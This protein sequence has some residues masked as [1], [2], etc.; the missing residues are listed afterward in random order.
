LLNWLRANASRYDAVIVHGLWQY[1]GLATWR[2]LVGTGTPYYVFPHGMLDPWFKQQFPLKHLKKT[3]YWPWAEYRVLRDAEAVLFTCEEE[4]QLARQT[5]SR[6]RVKEAVVGCGIS[7]PDGD[8]ERQR[9]KF[10]SRHPQLRD[11]RLML[12]LG[13][14]HPKKGCGQLIDAFAQ[15]AQRDPSLHLV[16]VGPAEADYQA[17]L[18][19][20]AEKLQLASRIC[21]TGMLRD[22]LKWGAYRA[23]EVFVLPSHQENF[24]ISVVEAL[25]CNVPV[26]VSNKVNIWRE[27]AEDRAGIVADD[28]PGGTLELLQSWLGLRAPQRLQMGLN[29]L[30]SFTKRFHIDATT[31]NLLNTIRASKCTPQRMSAA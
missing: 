29:G 23:A 17:A 8:P 15:V 21:W 1:H 9:E 14:L 28:T 10:F 18:A 30:A 25:A 2:A 19:S 20:R 12:F 6:Y 7:G 22:D 27:I 11:K 24:G 16:M 13:R 5:F 4:R 26:L 31:E 3:L